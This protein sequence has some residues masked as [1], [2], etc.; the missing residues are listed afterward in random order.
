M[1]QVLNEPSFMYSMQLHGTHART[2]LV[3]GAFPN[4]G[5]FD[6]LVIKFGG[7]TELL[8]Y[9]KQVHTLLGDS[10]CP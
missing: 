5:Y 6:K 8:P 1:P 3:F 10:T 9:Y 2:R 4:G 7:V